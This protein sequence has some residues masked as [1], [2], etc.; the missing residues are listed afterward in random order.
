[1]TE[2]DIRTKIVANWLLGHGFEAG[3]FKLEYV[4]SVRIGRDQIT[5][6]RGTRTKSNSI[7]NP[8]ADVL[9]IRNNQNL[10][11]VE[12]KAP[13]E[14]IESARDQG[15]SYARLLDQIAPFVV[16]TDGTT[17]RIYDTTRT[18]FNTST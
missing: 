16:A 13:G 7:A 9:V 5:T 1:M 12:V 2:E 6:G 11:I 14:S 10:M 17:S 4:F 8:R 3:E 18:A 15:I